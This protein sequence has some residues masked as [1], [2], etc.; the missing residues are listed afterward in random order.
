[1][2]YIKSFPHA[3]PFYTAGEKWHKAALKEWA[4]KKSNWH[5]ANKD[6]DLANF[7]QKNPHPCP[8]LQNWKAST[9]MSK[10]NLPLSELYQANLAGGPIP[11]IDLGNY[12]VL[13][14]RT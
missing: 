3:H 14:S 5:K 11:A 10:E 7:N 2:G 12:F 13:S 8:P 4:L 6:V 1:M 9:C